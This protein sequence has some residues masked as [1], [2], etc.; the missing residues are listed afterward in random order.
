MICDF[1]RH[2]VLRESGVDLIF[3]YVTSET[4]ELAYY[5]IINKSYYIELARHSY[6]V[7]MLCIFTCKY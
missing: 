3:E 6:K 7:H 5:T 2:C 4:L 1:K